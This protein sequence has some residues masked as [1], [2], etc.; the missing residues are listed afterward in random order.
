MRKQIENI[1]ESI[2]QLKVLLA[3]TKEEL[4]R[5]DVDKNMVRN[6]FIDLDKRLPII[7]RKVR[8]EIKKTIKLLE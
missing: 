1:N 8:L 3:V 6:L 4:Q 5:P 7:F 2:G